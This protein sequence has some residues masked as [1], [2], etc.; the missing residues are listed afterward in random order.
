MSSVSSKRIQATIVVCVVIVAA[1]TALLAYGN[2]HLP[3]L[4]DTGSPHN[5]GLSCNSISGVKDVSGFAK[6]NPNATKAGFLIV[7]SDSAPFEGMNGSYFHTFP[8][9][10]GYN[11]TLPNW[12]VIQAWQ[13]QTVTITIMNCASSEPHGF[14]I[15]NYFNAGVTLST[16]ETYTLTFE[17]GQKGKFSMYC[18]VFCSIHPYMQNG[19]LIVS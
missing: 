12:P 14:A 3:A 1:V 6:S 16:G 18:N 5:N 17:A 19:L 8:P 10:A 11:S 13:N 9:N 7:E 4:L 2:F 15:G